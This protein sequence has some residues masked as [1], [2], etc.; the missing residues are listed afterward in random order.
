AVVFPDDSLCEL[1]GVPIHPLQVYGAWLPLGILLGIA[2]ADR[3]GGE[4]IRPFLLPLMVGMYSLT[5]FGTEFLRPR[6]ANE[7]LTLSQGIELG[8]VL[9]VALL[10]GVGRKPW[11]YFLHQTESLSQPGSNSNCDC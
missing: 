2:F 6:R 8:A 4:T 3:V 9:S 11:R 7:A 10:L 5:R 1:A